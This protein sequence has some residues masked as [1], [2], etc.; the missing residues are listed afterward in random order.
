MS[1]IFAKRFPEFLNSEDGTAT[2]ESV[3]WFPIFMVV[4]FLA[5]DTSMMFAAETEAVRVVQDAN[6]LASIGRLD[7]ESDIETY[8]ENSL[9]ALSPNAIATTTISSVGVIRT[10]VRI[11]ASDVGK[12]G[13]FEAFKDLTLTISAEH[14]KEDFL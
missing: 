12:I 7:T 10:T 5:F 6:R 1:A 13:A 9:S 4:F 11:P 14:L 2:V 3:L 8:V